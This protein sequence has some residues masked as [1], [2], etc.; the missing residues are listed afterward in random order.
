MITSNVTYYHNKWGGL[1]V[2]VFASILKSQRIKPHEW[3]CVWSTMV[4]WLNVL[5]SNS[6]IGA[7]VDYVVYLPK[8][9]FKPTQNSDM[10]H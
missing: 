4:Y 10:C 5:L 6:K 2:R 7:Y 1:M 3:Y 9:G 8:L